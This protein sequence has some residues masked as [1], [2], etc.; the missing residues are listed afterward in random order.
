MKH[1]TKISG[2]LLGVIIV[3]EAGKKLLGSIVPPEEQEKRRK[4]KYSPYY[5]PRWR[6]TP[7]AYSIQVQV[8]NNS[9]MQRQDSV[10]IT[11]PAK[12]ANT[13]QLLPDAPS[14]PIRQTLSDPDQEELQRYAKGLEHA[15]YDSH[16]KQKSL[17]RENLI[18]VAEHKELNSTIKQM[19]AELH[20]A[21][22]QVHIQE[23]LVQKN[24]VAT[25][26]IL[27]LLDEEVSNL[28]QRIRD[29]ESTLEQKDVEIASLTSVKQLLMM[30]YSPK[31]G[32]P[33]D[34]SV[35]RLNPTESDSASPSKP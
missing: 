17:E 9:P 14:Q 10:G 20:K 15:Y 4:Q 6:A 1:D 30:L 26:D 23:M 29:L 32:S 2:F 11:A 3:A 18:L 7:P 19:K 33:I 24:L 13:P 21:N 16:I 25:K 27:Y 22:H 28:K 34:P 31:D 8:I 12:I 5:D 35:I